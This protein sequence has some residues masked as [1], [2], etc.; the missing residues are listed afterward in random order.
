[1]ARLAMLMLVMAT[2]YPTRATAATEHPPVGSMQ[3]A[4]CGSC[5]GDVMSRR[6]MHGP[7]ASG[8][9]GA[10]HVV[11]IASGRRRVALKNGA[12]A[13]D[14]TALCVS[15]HADTAVRLRQPYRHAPVAAGTCTVCHDPHGSSSRALL[16]ADGNGVCMKCHED[17]GQAL[18]QP[19][20]HGPAAMSCAICHDAH[21]GSHPAQLKAG[22]NVI[23]LACHLDTPVDQ[24]VT[25]PRALFGGG[26]NAAL[27]R[28]TATA[29]RIAL[30]GSLASGHPTIR[31]PVDGARDPAE[32]A[33]R[34]RCV[35]CHNAHGTS[36]AKL[37]RFGA[38]G[39]SPLCIRCHRF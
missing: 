6:V 26:P 21:A 17:I 1:M 15:C 28:L 23:C 14:V 7:T 8:D 27:D 25:D 29:P 30:D 34:L 33:Q 39:A 10:C 12:T 16:P 18:A 20:V 9:C 22:G 38:T 19:H 11:D 36:G 13:K 24:P 32:P 31:H 2:L 4:A 35:S 5:H 37:L 3:A